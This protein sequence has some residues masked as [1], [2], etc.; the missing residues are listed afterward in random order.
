MFSGFLSARYLTCE[1]KQ[2]MKSIVVRT[3]VGVIATTSCCCCYV[4]GLATV[5]P[6]LAAATTAARTNNA[7]RP[8][9]QRSFI[10]TRTQLLAS[11]EPTPTTTL[12]AAATSDPVTTTTPGWMTRE[13]LEEYTSNQGV[14][15]GLSTLGPGFRAVARAAHNTT[16][17][18]GYVEGFVR[19]SGTIVHFDT[20]QVFRPIVQRCRRENPAFT[21]GGTNLGVGLWLGY[22]CL[23]HAVASSSSKTTSTN[24]M[25]AEFLAIHDADAQHARL[26]RYYT[27]AGFGVVKYVGDDWRDIPDRLVWGGCGTLLRQDV[28]VLLTKWTRLLSKSRA[29]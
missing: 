6:W 7:R 16:L 8:L 13:Q 21:G 26:V 18:L 5:E 25:T 17:I 27:S 22:L 24:S 12:D 10:T 1:S 4:T 23:L 14:I 11:V 29:Q 15:I 2:N 9:S 20:M 3:L 19:P 28:A